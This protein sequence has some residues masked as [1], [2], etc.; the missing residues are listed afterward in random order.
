MVL[1]KLIKTL[2]IFITLGLVSIG[3][4]QSENLTDAERTILLKKLAEIREVAERSSS[5][6]FGSA[7]RAYR[8]A[9]KTDGGAHELYMKCTEKS[10]FI[11]EKKSSQ[12]YRDWKRRHKDNQ[13]CA[14]FRRALQHQLSWLLLTIEA[15][16]EPDEIESLGRKALEKV[17]AIMKDHEDL[18]EYR[19][20]LKQDVLSSVYARSYNI[21]GLE[22]KDWPKSPL[23]ISEIYEKLVFPPLRNVS[24]VSELRGAWNKRIEHEGLMLKNWA[25]IPDSGKIGMKRDMLPPAYEKW[26]E[27]PYLDLLWKREK[28]CYEAGDEKQAATNMLGHLSKYIRHKNSLKWTEDFEALMDVDDA[29]VSLSEGEPEGE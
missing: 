5:E 24:S 15:C 9:V 1:R 28:E 10:N 20:V 22:A 4:A 17:D 6:R 16:A 25:K 2:G 8:E 3:Q 19:D 12:A 26:K 29:A 18:K 23:D 27:G 11:D 14:E 7:L 13:D 21:N